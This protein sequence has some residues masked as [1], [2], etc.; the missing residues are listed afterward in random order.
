MVIWTD[1][2]GVI[3]AFQRYC[4]DGDRVR[5]NG[6]NSGLLTQMVEIVQQLGLAKGHLL[7]VPTHQSPSEFFNGLERCLVCGNSAAD[8]AA[9]A[10]NLERSEAVWGLWNAYGEPGL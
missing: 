1:C 10:A 5:V 6:R 7:E 4:R 2:L 9:G 3:N 8:A